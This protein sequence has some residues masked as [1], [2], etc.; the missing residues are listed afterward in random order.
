MGEISKEEQ[1]ILDKVRR[2]TNQELFDYFFHGISQLPPMRPLPEG[3]H[4]DHLD[5]VKELEWRLRKI[6]FLPAPSPKEGT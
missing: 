6:A 2:F 3:I 5:L 1:A 4:C